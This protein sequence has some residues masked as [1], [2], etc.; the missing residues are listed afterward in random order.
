MIREIRAK[1]ILNTFQ[2]KDDWFG[3]KYSMNVYRG[4]QHQCIYCDSRSACYQIENFQDVLGKVNA[5][6]LLRM[7]RS[8]AT[9]AGDAE[10]DASC[11]INDDGAVNAIDLLILARN[12]AL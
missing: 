2:Q 9:R 8:W 10:Y 12:W 5:I 7:V 6:D 3:I 4:C 11:D 1:S